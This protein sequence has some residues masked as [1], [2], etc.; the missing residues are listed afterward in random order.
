MSDIDAILL[1]LQR[2]ADPARRA[3]M[4]AYMRDQFE[5]L[6]VATPVRR[7]ATKALYKDMKSKSA[8]ELMALAQALWDHPAREYQYAA[9]DLLAAHSSKFDIQHLPFLMSLVQSKSWWDTVDATATV[10]GKVLK[11]RHVG[12]D[13]AV[14]HENMWV[15]RVAILHQ[16][17]WRNK[18]DQ[19]LLFSY[20]LQRAHEKEFFIQ[21]AIGWALRDYARHNPQ[22]VREFTLAEKARLS[23]LS[24]REANKH[25]APDI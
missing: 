19:A 13:E 6:G 11:Y 20:S 12:M 4:R 17:G 3:P 22:A 5:F 10:I 8:D 1:A 7:D 21:K 24:Y 14:S 23:P 16:L 15:R 18:T 25:L 9:I 2:A